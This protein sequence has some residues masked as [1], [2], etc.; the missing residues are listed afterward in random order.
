MSQIRINSIAVENYR[1]FKELQPFNFP[2]E[3]YKKPVAIVNIYHTLETRKHI[4]EQLKKSI[5]PLC[6]VL[7][8]G[9]VEGLE[10]NKKELSYEL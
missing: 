5:K 8:R 7:M 1:S 4:D 6:P 10:T 9:V 2:D 3:D